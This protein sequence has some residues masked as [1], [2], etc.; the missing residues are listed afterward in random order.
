MSDLDAVTLFDWFTNQTHGSAYQETQRYSYRNRKA[1]KKIREQ[2]VDKNQTKKISVVSLQNQK[3][4]I[5]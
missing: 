1:E 2:E 3:E 5:S 4:T